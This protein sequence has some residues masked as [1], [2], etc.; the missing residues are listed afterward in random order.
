M[1]EHSQIQVEQLQRES[2]DADLWANRLINGARRSPDRLVDLMAE[3]VGSP[4]QTTAHFA[5]EL[6]AHL[7]DEESALPMV[8]LNR[9]LGAPMLEVLQQE[10]HRQVVQQTSPLA[11]V[12]GSCRRKIMQMQWEELFEAVDPTDVVLATIRQASICAWISRRE[13]ATG[14]PS[15]R[16]PGGQSTELEVVAVVGVILLFFRGRNGKGKSDK[17]CDGFVDGFHDRNGYF[18]SH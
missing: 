18:F 15:R 5:N 12:I 2:E 3:L 11:N 13:I 7:Y 16:S 6:V 9:S 14:M 10:H 1:F 8:E 4:F 17:E